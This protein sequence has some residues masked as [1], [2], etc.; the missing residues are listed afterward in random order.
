MM[1]RQ[2]CTSTS[3]MSRTRDSCT[4][5]IMQPDGATFSFWS[6][7][8]PARKLGVVLSTQL[9]DM[10]PTRFIH[11][12]RVGCGSSHC[13]TPSCF[14]C[15]KRLV[16]NGP[17]RRHSPTSAR[18][19]AVYLA[20]REDFGK[21]LC[22]YLQRSNEPP[23]ATSNLIFS[24][25]RPRVRH[26][27]GEPSCPKTSSVSVSTRSSDDIDGHST[28]TSLSSPK[29]CQCPL[30]EGNQPD[31]EQVARPPRKEGTQKSRR[32]AVDGG[33]SSRAKV[34]IGE[35]PSTRDHRSFAAALF[36]TTAFKM[37][38]WL[39][40][41]SLHYIY[42][43]CLEARGP[44]P[45]PE[46]DMV[47]KSP[48][49]AQ[50]HS[51]PKAPTSPGAARRPSSS[52]SSRLSAS[53]ERDRS[54]HTASSRHG[55]DQ[56]VT[57]PTS[58]TQNRPSK[59]T[60][61]DA[62]PSRPTKRSSMD[63]TTASPTD[64]LKS[65]AKATGSP[66]EIRPRASKLNS[67]VI[68][69]AVPD[70]P[71]KQAFFENVPCPPPPVISDVETITLEQD[72]AENEL[73]TGDPPTPSAKVEKSRG[74]PDCH[75]EAIAEVDSSWTDYPPPQVLHQLNVELVDFICDVFQEDRSSEKGFFWSRM[76]DYSFPLPTSAPNRMM[77]KAGHPTTLAASLRKQWKM[78][79]EQSIFHVMSN[80]RL[81]VR[82]FTRDGKLFDSHTLWYCMFRMTRT[83]P[84]L[85]LHSLWLAAKTLFVPPPS[86]KGTRIASKKPRLGGHSALSDFEAGCVMS[87]CLHALVA[88]VPCVPDNRTLYEM[89]RIRSSG[90]VISN[91][92]TTAG[93]P[94]S[95][96]LDYD[97]VFSNELALRLAR[98]IFRAITARNCFAE[99][100]VY[101]TDDE[102]DAAGQR[103]VLGLLLNQL[104]LIGNN[105]PV[106]I[107]EFSQAERQLHETRVPTLLLDWARAVLL[108]E[109][110]GRLE[111]SNES[112]IHG[113]MA[114]VSTLCKRL[115]AF[116]P[117][118][119]G[120]LFAD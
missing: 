57:C 28:S 32:Q 35:K 107:L 19:L 76:P 54:R 62:T 116:S 69:K 13:T 79:N 111:Y 71:K 21:R 12:L 67:A 49:C 60:R 84:S 22:P 115:A 50:T 15:R 87:I 95:T 85:V 43:Q 37:L 51:E 73:S 3:K 14:T 52:R 9:T 4:L 63:A 97:A 33:A 30:A 119:W 91:Q 42:D 48:E 80:P 99:I 88:A 41:Q 1:L 100:A 98:R 108:H 96:C 53:R 101:E 47:R 89:S 120:S 112:P 5:Y 104:D 110:N 46:Q 20:S 24:A 68:G 31:R 26:S 83:A 45:S 78:F 59:S 105:G 102:E 109:W 66:G 38:E 29:S 103:N 75:K 117:V 44:S 6:T 56:P 23:P 106:R 18:M 34:R 93:R 64:A 81:L 11:Q 90:R 7:G 114:L 16:A 65:T 118:F 61:N 55:P 2:T 27:V 70:I 8:E 92:W 36:G 25:Q 74:K 86:L 82:S 17:V 40:P 39:T 113:A 10:I 77:R 58:S 94:S 72:G